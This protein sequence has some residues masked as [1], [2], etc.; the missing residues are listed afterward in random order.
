[1]GRLRLGHGEIPDDLPPAEDVAEDERLV[2][3]GGEGQ[4]RRRAGADPAPVLRAR[5]ELTW[6][7]APV[8]RHITDRI[9]APPSRAA[10]PT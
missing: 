8:T 10:G 3:E 1:M 5:A 2:P 6:I 9:W 4:R 7:A